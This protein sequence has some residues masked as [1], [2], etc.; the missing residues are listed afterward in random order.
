MPRGEEPKGEAGLMREENGM[1][2]SEN[3][4]V[5]QHGIKLLFRSWRPKKWFDRGCY[6]TSAHIFSLVSRAEES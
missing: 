1:E 6:R 3:E 5:R 4:R 2:I